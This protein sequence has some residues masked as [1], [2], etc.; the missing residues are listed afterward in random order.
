MIRDGYADKVFC[1]GA[2]AMLDVGSFAAWDQLGVMSRNP[3]A[4]QACRPF[5]SDRDG[6][7]LGEGAGAMI[8]ES[9][10]SAKSRHSHILAELCGYGESSDALHITSPNPEGQAKAIRAAIQ[11][12]GIP[13]EAIGVINAHGTATR[14]NDECEALSIR[15][16][17]GDEADRIPVAANKSYFGHLLGA[18]GVV[19]SVVT[20]LGLRAE[21]VPPNLNLENQDPKCDIQLLGSSPT[22]ICAP[23]AMKNSFGFGGSNAVLVFRR[24]EDA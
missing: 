16:A 13:A 23:V 6:C 3:D 22:Q 18:S 5:D 19:E 17:L 9:A 10:E 14:A 15:M 2:D 7:V 24:W 12:A 1:G 20:I 11:S 8:L 21:T 4:L